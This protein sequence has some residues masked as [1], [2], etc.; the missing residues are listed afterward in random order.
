MKNQQMKQCWI[1]ISDCGH[2]S[3]FAV[4]PALPVLAVHVEDS[5][6][7]VLTPT[8]S[9]FLEGLVTR[10]GGWVRHHAEVKDFLVW[11]R[12]RRRRR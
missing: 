6:E 4:R 1:H 2:E 10:G 3:H 5:F 8:G 9:V 12:E 7:E 11:R